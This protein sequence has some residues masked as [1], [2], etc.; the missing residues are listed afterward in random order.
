VEEV[1][2]T[3]PRAEEYDQRIRVIAGREI[4]FDREGFLWD[5][6]EWSEE[7]ALALAKESGLIDLNETQWRILRFLREYYFQNGR[8]P[9]NRQIKQGTG[10]SLMEMEAL[11][12]EGIKY[13]ARRLAGLPNPKNCN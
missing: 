1:V 4:L 8:S 2:R 9:L 6:K 10:I 12:P 7:V 13:G 11:F 5:P 3:P